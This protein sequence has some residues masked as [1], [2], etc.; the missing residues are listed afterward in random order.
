MLCLGIETTCDES[1]L[2]LLQDGRLLAEELAS[3]V[4]MHALFGGVVPELA[5]REHL[6][7]LTPL[8]DQ[9][10]A[11]SGTGPEDLD[12]IAV[13]RGPGLLGSILIGM[14][15]GKGLA[16]ST[17]APLIGVDHLRAHLLAPDLEQ[18]IPFPA[19]GLLIS[20]G[21][22]R[23]YLIRSPLEFELLGRTLD[24]A[25]GEA[26]DKTARL[27]NLP[28]P[29]GKHID[30]LAGS[31]VPETTLFP[32]PYL[33]NANLDFSFSGLKTAVA[34]Y[35]SSHPELKLE[36]LDPEPDYDRIISQNKDLARVCASLNWSIARTLY[37]KT[38]RGL[39]ARNGVRSLLVAGGVAANT[40]I[41]TT[42]Q[43]LAREHGL[44]LV[45]PSPELC[46]DN[47]A[48]IANYGFHLFSAGYRHGLDF[49]AVPRGRAMPFDYICTA[50]T[51]RE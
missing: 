31:A 2:A 15:L 17:D 23:I 49:D 26:F 37:Q 35:V 30:V 29:G 21:H 40:M 25:V 5:S 41:R 20:G 8:L 9:L 6:R 19:L 44:P 47:A 39:K 28:Y 27:L 51:P 14:A 1:A 13:A 33:D 11:R 3:Q 22:T 10:F 16:L 50:G 12:C 46:T 18:D 4:D 32:C 34:Q 7:I 42:M 43:E 38:K 24:D 48:M 45:L 36:R